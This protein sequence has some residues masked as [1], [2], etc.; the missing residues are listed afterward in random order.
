MKYDEVSDFDPEMF[1]EY[2]RSLLTSI[3]KFE[4]AYFHQKLYL[5]A[6]ASPGLQLERFFFCPE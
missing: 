1:K 2:F 3:L 4:A 5:S 6:G